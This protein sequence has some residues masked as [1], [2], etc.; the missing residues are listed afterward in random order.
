MLMQDNFNLL[1]LLNLHNNFYIFGGKINF[2]TND[3][4]FPLPPHKTKQ[5]KTI[6]AYSNKGIF[7][8]GQ[9]VS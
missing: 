4:S 2:S 7:D 1:S 3:L 6:R 5:S 9:L 8:K